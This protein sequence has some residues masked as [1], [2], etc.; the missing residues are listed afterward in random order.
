MTR[1]LTFVPVLAACGGS[2]QAGDIS[3]REARRLASTYM[4]CY[5]TGCGGTKEPLARGNVWEIPLLFG[6]AGTPHGVIR[7]DK[8]TG[9]VSYSYAGQHYPT[10]S[11][12][13]LAD[14]ADELV[15][16]R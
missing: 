14:R 4:L 5:I 6:F 12:K 9:I 7:V 16:R 11:P 2:V 13:Q 1:I 10:V 8:A 15:P 3:A